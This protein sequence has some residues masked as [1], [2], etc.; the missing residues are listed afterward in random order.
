[1]IK[2][3]QNFPEYYI[4]AVLFCSTYTPPLSI[5]SI[6]IGL[7]IF[8]ALQSHYKWKFTGMLIS[9]LFI[10]VNL[11]MSLALLSELKEFPTFTGQ[12]LLMLGVGSFLILLNLIVSGL[13]IYNYSRYDASVN[14][15]QTPGILPE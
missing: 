15:S 7:I 14:L 3:K 9:T 5:S 2:L 11:Y 8:L 10:A 1:M 12:A 13:M 6:A 4:I